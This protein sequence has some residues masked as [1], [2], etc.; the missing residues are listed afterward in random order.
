[1]QTLKPFP[2]YSGFRT[3]RGPKNRSYIAKWDFK[4]L[5]NLLQKCQQRVISSL[6]L[7]L[8]PLQRALPPGSLWNEGTQAPRGP[9]SEP[10]RWAG[11]GHG[12]GCH[13]PE[14]SHAPGCLP[15]T[16]PLSPA[17]RGRGQHSPLF[18]SGSGHWPLTTP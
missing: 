10:C 1:M 2:T 8:F 13:Q 11:P 18:L 9:C 6:L 7:V 14:S 3:H 5:P 4:S 12:P 15:A 16:F 17:R